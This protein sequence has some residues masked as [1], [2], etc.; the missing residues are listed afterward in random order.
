[1]VANYDGDDPVEPLDDEDPPGDTGGHSRALPVDTDGDG[2]YDRLLVDRDG[3]G[4]Y[5]RAIPYGD[6][7]PGRR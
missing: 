7:G 2:D 3:D 4:D 1:V 5:D 6:D